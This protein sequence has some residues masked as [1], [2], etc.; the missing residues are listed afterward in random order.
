MMTREEAK[1]KN[2]PHSYNPNTGSHGEFRLKCTAEKCPKWRDSEIQCLWCKHNSD[3][4]EIDNG[5]PESFTSFAY[6]GNNDNRAIEK[7]VQPIVCNKCQHRY[8]HCGG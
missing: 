5:C 2:C 1:N 7:N 8:G 6:I 4:G 3:Y